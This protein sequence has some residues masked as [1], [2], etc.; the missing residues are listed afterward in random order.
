[1]TD[2]ALAAVAETADPVVVP[3]EGPRAVPRRALFAADD[4]PAP[5]GRFAGAPRWMVIFADLTALLIAFFVLMLSMSVFE[6]DAMARLNGEPVAAPGSGAAPD[7]ASQRP[8]P[9]LDAAEGG[10]GARYLGGLLVQQISTIDPALAV[11][12]DVR[13]GGVVVT[14]PLEA[15]AAAR[16]GTDIHAVLSRVSAAAPGRMTLMAPSATGSKAGIETAMA[17][18][19]DLDAGIGFAGWLAS[20]TAAIAIAADTATRRGRR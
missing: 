8:L 1:M 11:S 5:G 4:R 7:T 17:A 16:T 9:P 12:L 2:A 18:L 3:E 19:P 14:L 13:D 20:D 6:P 15:L 10:A